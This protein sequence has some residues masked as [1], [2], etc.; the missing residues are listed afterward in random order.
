MPRNQN[1]FGSV[2]KRNP[3]PRSVYV[4]ETKGVYTHSCKVVRNGVKH[5]IF[6]GIEPGALSSKVAPVPCL[7]TK[8]ESRFQ[9]SAL[10]LSPPALFVF[11]VRFLSR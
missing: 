2:G 11:V 3:A 6:N 1:F 10:H 9:G 5:N 8:T 4:L 7:A